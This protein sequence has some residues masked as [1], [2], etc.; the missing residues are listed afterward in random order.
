MRVDRLGL[1][2]D[3][4]AGWDVR[5]F[6]RPAAQGA[7]A[8]PVMHLASFALP[9]R[10][11]DFGSGAVERMRPD[12]ILVVLFEYDEEAVS[13]PLFAKR[14]RPRPVAA[15]FSPRQLQ[16]TLPGQSGVQY[17][18]S[19]AGR[20][21]CLYIVLGSHGARAALVPSVTALLERLRIAARAAT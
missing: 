19:E 8:N 2:A 7:T 21:F 15:D 18:Y 12:D 1:A 11:G 9:E 17:F 10:R 14:G 5:V 6:R 4:P 20:A 16:R 13:T 3:V